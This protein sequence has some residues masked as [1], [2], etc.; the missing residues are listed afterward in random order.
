LLCLALDVA[1]W[2]AFSTQMGSLPMTAS[3][4]GLSEM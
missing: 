2:M 1:N 4:A 3:V